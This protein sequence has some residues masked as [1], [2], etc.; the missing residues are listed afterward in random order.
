MILSVFSELGVR[1]ALAYLAD[2]VLSKA[3]AGMVRVRRYLFFVQPLAD[4]RVRVPE[5]MHLDTLPIDFESLPLPVAAQVIRQRLSHGAKCFV[6]RIRGEFAGYA[7]FQ[8]RAYQ[9][10]EVR[11]EFIP[12]PESVIWDYDIYIVPKYRSTRAFAVL[13]QLAGARLREKGFTHTAS[14]IAGYNSAS[15]RSHARLGARQVGSA[16]FVT[17]GPWQL[18]LHRGLSLTRRYVPSI[19]ITVAASSHLASDTRRGRF[20]TSA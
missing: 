8:D 10:D 15:I 11:C 9:E 7:W 19:C 12:N 1:N 18:M 6:L 2:R 4:V 20:R 3:T 16:V 14:R 17:C 5:N 13:W